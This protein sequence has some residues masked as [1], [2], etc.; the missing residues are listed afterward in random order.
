MS[1]R[2][3]SAAFA[4]LAVFAALAPEDTSARATVHP[5]VAHAAEYGS[6][7][8]LVQ[9]AS[10][11]P[12]L[13]LKRSAGFD[14]RVRASRDALRASA[15]SSQQALRAALDAR[16]VHYRAFWIVDALQLRATPD[17]LAWLAARDDVHAIVPNQRLRKEPPIAASASKAIDAIAWGVDRVRA[18][19]V[20]ELGY[21]GTGV[22]VAGQDT[23]Y[24]WDHPALRDAYRGWNGSSAVHDHHWHDAIVAGDTNV[25]GFAAT[26][27]CDDDGH[28]TH[29]MGTIVGDDG[30]TNQI[31]VAPAARWIGC[32][33]MD[34]GNGTVATYL[35]CFEWFL[36]PT[37]LAGN[38]AQPALAPHIINN[39]WGCP[40]SE[41]CTDVSVLDAG[42]AAV[43]D[44]GIFIVAS[45]GNEGG[46]CGTVASPPGIHR[47]AFTV[48][49]TNA[50]DAIAVFSS[51]GPVTVDG[52]G[53]L[54]PDVT[55]PGVQVR[56]S[57]PGNAYG[58]ASGTSMAGPHV[59]GIA[60]LM[61]D[62]N[63]ALIGDPETVAALLRASAIPTT[64][65]QTCG[66]FPGA[67]V[68]NA[69]F[70]HGRVDALAAVQAALALRAPE[71][72][73]DG[74]E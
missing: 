43:H 63:P 20:W 71:M 14:A 50:V 68:P 54:K 35:D 58:N 69:V 74:F 22:V 70:G 45:A 65:A 67:L 6:V 62:A 13:P 7:D 23:G 28:G 51:R 46:V 36:A 44:A 39:S 32:R 55:A 30:G 19:Q 25:C 31:G 48:G 40:P 41:G 56:S 60:A 12:V 53:R 52:S 57:V 18:P 8:V 27:P 11:V 73:E 1:G 72:F 33:N 9:L 49:A 24:Q 34:D 15:G 42:I 59:A 37:D 38:D 10:D 21:L 5:A 4:S 3:L 47:D 64:S 26:V 16:G 61:M 66:A 17:D 2:Y 29:T